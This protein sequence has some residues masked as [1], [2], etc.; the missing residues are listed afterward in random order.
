MKRIWIIAFVFIV[1]F[2]AGFA[3]KKPITAFVFDWYL[4]SYCQSCLGATL[5]YHSMHQEGDLWILDNP[6]IVTKN[7]LNEGGYRFNA[8]KAIIDASVIWFSRI[9]DLAFTFDKPHLDVGKEARD[10]K[11]IFDSQCD[12]FRFFH[13]YMHFKTPQGKVLLHS[14]IGDNALPFFFSTDFECKNTSEGCLS[15]W[16]DEVGEDKEIKISLTQPAPDTFCMKAKLDNVDSQVMEQWIG[17]FLPKLSFCKISQGTLDGNLSITIPPDTIPY[18][19]AQLTLENVHLKHEG[20]ECELTAPKIN[21]H[22]TSHEI[23]QDD[24]VV[25]QTIGHMEIPKDISL[26]F[27]K[28]GQS[29]WTVED[30]KGSFNFKTFDSANFNM[31]GICRSPEKIRQLQVNGQAGF[32]RTFPENLTMGFQLFERDDGKVDP[33]ASSFHFSVRQLGESWSFAEVEC[34]GFGKEECAFAQT[35]VCHIHPQWQQ[36]DI[37]SGTLDAAL[38]VYLHGINVAEVKV[39]HINVH[40]LDFSFL[41]LDLSGSVQEAVGLLSFDLSALKPIETLN[42]D[43]KI[44]EGTLS[45]PVLDHIPWQFSGIHTDLS[46]RKGVM[47]KSL[48]KGL[49]AG[50]EGIIEIDGTH[51]DSLIN[52]N[53]EGHVSDLEHVLPESFVKTGIF[54]RF[55]ENSLKVSAAGKKIDKGMRFT[56][57]VEIENQDASIENIAFKFNLE[58]ALNNVNKKEKTHYQASRCSCW[59]GLDI[60]GAL[61]PS[62]ALPVFDAYQEKIRDSFQVPRYTIVNGWF[63]ANR[64]PLDKYISPLVF[65]EH[66]IEIY[67]LGDFCGSFDMQGIEIFYDAQDLVFENSDFE[68]EIKQLSV[69]QPIEKRFVANYVFDF[70]RG[71]GFGEIPIINGSYLEKNSGLLFTDVCANAVLETGLM[72]VNG[73]ETFCEGIYFYGDL[74]LDWRMPGKGIFD[75]DIHAQ[76]MKGKVSQVKQF[77]SHFDTSFFFF[78]LPVEGTVT[79]IKDGCHMAFGFQPED[80]S[81]QTHIEGAVID[82]F[83]V[84]SEV[85]LQLQDLNINFQYDKA[86]NIFEFSDLQGTVLVGTPNHFEEYALTGERLIFSDYT[87]GQAEFDVCIKDKQRDIIRVAGRTYGQPIENEE[88]LI[89]FVFDHGLTHFGDVHLAQSRFA[90]KDWSQIDTFHLKFDFQLQRLLADLQRFSRTGLLFLSRSLLKELNHVETA[91]GNF[92]VSLDYDQ[93]RS[94]FKYDIAGQEVAI[95]SHQFQEFSLIGNKKGDVWTVDQLKLD[96]FSLAFD[97]L[98]KPQSWNINFLGARIGKSILLGLEGHFYPDKSLLESKINLLEIDLSSSTVV[99]SLNAIIDN[100]QLGGKIR[101]AGF[102]NISLDSLIPKEMNVELDLK[103][104][105]NQGRIKGLHLD[106]M[107]NMSLHY[108]TNEGFELKEIR[109]ALKSE[110]NN[111]LQATLYL[112]QCCWKSANRELQT[113][114]V[115]FRIPSSNLQWLSENLQQSFPEA[116]SQPVADIIRF[117]KTDGDIQGGFQGSISD[118]ACSFRLSLENGSYCLMGN[119]YNLNNFSLV[120]NP[121]HLKISAEYLHHQQPLWVEINCPSSNF[122]SGDLIV[123]E[124]FTNACQELE[125][126][127]LSILWQH[128][129]H[130]GY[131]IQRATGS[132]CGLSCNLSRNPESPF[133]ENSFSLS[134]KVDIDGRH[135]KRLLDNELSAKLAAWEL[136]QG[137]SLV[138][139]WSITKDPKR[140]LM[141]CL[142]FH[143]ELY[144]NNFEFYGYQ[145]QHLSA[146]LRYTPIAVYLSHLLVIDPCCNLQ[147]PEV[148]SWRHTDGRWIAQIPQVIVQDF[149]PS[150]MRCM[151]LGSRRIG[152]SL[153]I[154]ELNIDNLNGYLDD[155]N[156][157]TG[158]GVLNFINPPKNNVQHNIFT[159]PIEILQRIGLDLAVL[160]PVR[161]TIQYEIAD[162]KVVL[163]RF[164]DMYSKNKMSKFYL[165]NNRYQSYLDLDGNLHVQVRMKQYNLIFKLAELFTFTIQGTLKKPT[166]TLQKQSSQKEAKAA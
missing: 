121:S 61:L 25:H 82:G 94:L 23:L 104:S 27:Y 96:D 123:T 72:H 97:I 87:N 38:L 59:A 113:N 51:P 155:R 26:C 98:K 125:H 101:A 163:N 140:T 33:N 143:G 144:G 166:Y 76:K 70:Q 110:K 37:S 50:L 57:K 65:P 116:I 81:F 13:V 79:F 141:D 11:S 154:R 48:L 5:T 149:R 75:I 43:L 115:F 147:M 54:D 145:F 44:I 91:E 157:F 105:L 111:I 21:I 10:L 22:L 3:L 137:Y 86:A 46:I 30:L 129:P 102:L 109:T 114:G 118:K 92:Q 58:Q 142:D 64:L 93:M 31:K 99:P 83:L 1:C 29:Y 148:T 45:M 95:G 6:V 49:I 158:S 9:I 32:E 19:E 89:D 16:F 126:R 56:G 162:G 67:G 134:G 124:Q 132:I 153:V 78:K 7:S 74:L 117:A 47:Q 73:L 108:A 136:G 55:N 84:C 18:A 66:N 12:E 68:I 41:P 156:S 164:K 63:E 14:E 107:T 127:S 85:D 122:E 24:S 133:N 103:L 120:H 112:Q 146:T 35:I 128:Q 130:A 69:G 40:H 151:D 42:A 53:F 165:P 100:L 15:M 88:M 160:N 62:L 8:D 90:L 152:K 106:D 2:C 39:E 119:E 4:K 36:L 17:V 138:G 28:N 139:N 150:L 20:L 80:Y 34:V 60:L 135:I 77:F 52:L 71:Q 159:I 161:G 131:F